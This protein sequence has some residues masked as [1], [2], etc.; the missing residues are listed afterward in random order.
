MTITINQLSAPKP[1]NEGAPW[2]CEFKSSSHSNV[3]G[4]GFTYYL[5][6]QQL[7]LIYEK[8]GDNTER[9]KSLPLNGA[10]LEAV[11]AVIEAVSESGHGTDCPYLKTALKEL[12]ASAGL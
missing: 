1:Y 4:F 9:F 7:E 6:D 10:A 2:S 5:N 11:E 8:S 12:I 3:V